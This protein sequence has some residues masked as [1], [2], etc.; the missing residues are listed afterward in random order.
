MAK[1]AKDDEHYVNNKEL[2]TA[3]TVYIKAVRKSKRDKT[4]HPQIT[5]Y[6]AE[7]I[8]K[9]AHGTANRNNFMNYPFKEDMIAD[10]IENCLKYIDNFDPKQVQKNPFGYFSRIIFQAFVRRIQKEKTHLYTKYKAIEN[11]MLL[12]F[13]EH[14][15]NEQLNAPQKYISEQSD[16]YMQEFMTNFERAYDEKKEKLKESKKHKIA[17]LKK[18]LSKSRTSAKLHLKD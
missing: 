13:Y 17:A 7:S 8:V 10:G 6:I 12:E 5:D 15:N 3:M 2:Y 11:V 16:S 18:S 14:A 1:I 4:E 9:I